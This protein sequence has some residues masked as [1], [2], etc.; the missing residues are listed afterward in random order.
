MVVAALLHGQMSDSARCR[1]H[2]IFF[3]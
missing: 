3:V 1:D 2:H